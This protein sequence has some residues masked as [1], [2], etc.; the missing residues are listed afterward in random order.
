MATESVFGPQL[1]ERRARLERAGQGG[2]RPPE[3]ARL[4]AEVDAAL[5]RLERGSFG[6]CETCHDPIEP[7]HLRAD[8]LARFC[9]D[10]LTP[11][12]Q[13]DLQRDLELAR[14]I[15]TALLPQRETVLPGWDVHYLY[16]PAGVVSGDTCD[17]WP[18]GQGG[19]QLVLGDVAGKGVAASLLMANLQAIFRALALS[20]LPLGERVARAN[21]LFCEATL[22]SSYATLVAARGGAGGEVELVNAGHCPPLLLHGGRVEGLPA[23]GLPLGLFCSSSYPS[24]RLE[25]GRDDLLLLYTDGLSEA[26]SATGEELGAERLERLLAGLPVGLPAREVVAAVEQALLRFLD[27]APR[28]DDLT[29]LALRR[30]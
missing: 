26:R 13:D 25:L 15:Q 5:E 16:R 30:A 24:T 6:L 17:V 22:P 18:E 28:H 14:R 23:S 2:A 9:L 19:F 8:P 3:V 21:H 12:E 20:G 7:E 1:R 10:H 27:G 29:V 11:T 4:L